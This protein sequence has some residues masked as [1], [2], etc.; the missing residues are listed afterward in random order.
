MAATVRSRA[1]ALIPTLPASAKHGDWWPRLLAL[2]ALRAV[3]SLKYVEGPPGKECMQRAD[4]TIANGGECKALSVVFAT[5]CKI[6]GIPCE[7]IFVT[8]TGKPLN[9]VTTIVTLD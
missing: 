7:I 2:E 3:Q 4:Y 1:S 8:Q 9:H 6:L 5:V